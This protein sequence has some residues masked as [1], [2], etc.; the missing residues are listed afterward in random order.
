[1]SD[2]VAIPARAMVIM[3]HPD[4]AEFV[5]AGTV[6]LWAQAGCAICY[7]VCTRGDR[8]SN[9]PTITPWALAR[10]REQEQ[11]AACDILGVQELVL[12]DHPDGTLEPTLALRRDLT[13][14]IRRFRPQVVLT[15]DPTARFYGD[16]Y[17]NH[18]DHRAAGSAALDAVFPSAETRYV[19]PEL[20]AQGLEPH[21]VQAVYIHGSPEPNVWIDIAPVLEIKAKALAAHRSQVGDGPVIDWLR[22]MAWEEGRA[23]GLQAAEAYRRIVIH[24]EGA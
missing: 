22:A 10:I 19:F 21:R 13:R 15:S 18:P 7:C 14:E 1:M 17:L 3:A 2:H 20:L 23:R 5:V 12:L 16:R 4:D 11:R 6:A 24:D 9:D 8:G